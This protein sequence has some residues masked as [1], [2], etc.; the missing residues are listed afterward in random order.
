[1]PSAGDR[2]KKLIRS[3]ETAKTPVMCVVGDKE[4]DSGECR[5]PGSPV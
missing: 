4:K 5:A 1:M 3:A 2:L